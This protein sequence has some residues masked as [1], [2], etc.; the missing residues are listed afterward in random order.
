M[1]HYVFIEDQQGDLIEL[2]YY[3]SDWCA[4]NDCAYA[5]WNGAHETEHDTP[6]NACGTIINGTLGGN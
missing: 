5:G 6:C 4:R 2:N 1:A 3:C